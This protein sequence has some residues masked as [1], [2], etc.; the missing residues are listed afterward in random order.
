LQCSCLV[1]ASIA[2]ASSSLRASPSFIPTS[3]AMTGWSARAAGQE[4]VVALVCP[5]CYRLQTWLSGFRA[6]CN[7]TVGYVLRTWE[8]CRSPPSR[9]PSLIVHSDYHS[10]SQE[11]LPIHL[12]VV[13][14]SSDPDQLPSWTSEFITTVSTVLRAKWRGV[15]SCDM[16]VLCRALPCCAVLYCAVLCCHS[17][18]PGGVPP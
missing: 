8:P 6:C 14:S 5:C 13:G 16:L 3:P 2:P 17:P 7:H 18:A 11:L 15:M 1:P 4:P 9:P 10:S 12:N